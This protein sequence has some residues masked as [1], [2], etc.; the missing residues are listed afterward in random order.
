MAR[1]QGKRMA[2]MLRR[3]WQQ[4][5]EAGLLGA[6]GALPGRPQLRYISSATLCRA[7]GS[8]GASSG[9]FD[10]SS[11]ATRFDTF[12]SQRAISASSLERLDRFAPRHNALSKADEEEMCKAI[13]AKDM[14]DLMD[15]AIP[16]GLP[17][18]DGLDLGIYTKGMS[19]SEFL[20]H[21]KAMT[22]KNKVA[23]SYLGMGYYGTH[24]PQVIM[25]NLLENPGWYTQYTPYQSEIAQGRLESLLNFQTMVADLTAMEM[26]QSSL[27]DE[28]TAAAEAM[29]MTSAMAKGKKTRFVV[30]SNCHPQT[31]AVCQS[32]ADGLGLTVDVVDADKIEFASDVCGALVQYPAT[33]GSVATYSA[34]ADAAH[35]ADSKLCVATDLL[36]LTLLKPP[37]EWGADIVVGSAQRLGVPMGFG[38][39][40]AAF[41]ACSQKHQRLMPGRIIAI[42]KDANGK[43]A[44][45]MAMQ[46]RE[47]HIRRD[48][49]TSNICTA[50]A[51]LANMAAMY[52]V[53]HGP[54][55]L[56]AIAQRCH[57]MA[58]VVAEG[59]RRAGHTVAPGP[60]F[61]TVCMD[62]GD[63][64]A[65]VARGAEAGINI[66]QLDSG[67]ITVSVDETTTL[68]D[69]DA[70]LGVLRVG[71]G[72]SAAELAEAVDADM[73]GDLARTSS[74]MTNAVFNQYHSEH[75]MLRYLKHLENR[76]LSL[77]H[78]MIPLGSCTMKLN[79]TAEMVPISWPELA[80]IH[81]FAPTDQTA[82]YRAM[83]DALAQQL[84]EIT[85]FD[86]VSLQPNAGAAGEYAGLMSIRSYHQ[87]RGQGH[88]NI[89]IVPTSA[90]GT[91]P[92]SAVMCGM[93]VVVVKT[94]PSG[95][96]DMED[97]K[98]AVAKHSDN[99]AAFMITY[100]STYGLFDAEIQELCSIIHENGGQVYMDGANMNAQVGVTAPGILGADVC[101][102]N[103]HKT[104]CI[105]HG[106][107]GP[108]MG[109]IG[110]KAHLAPFLPSHPVIPTGGLPAPKDAT[111]APFGTMAAAPYGSALILPISFA[112]ISMMGSDGLRAATQQ[113]ILAANYM[114]EKLGG[115]Y[116]VLYQNSAGRCAHEFIIDLRGFET[117][118]GITP[119]DVAKRLLDY[120]FHG[121]TMSWPVPG[122]LM[123]EPTESEPK[124]E[125]DRFVEA[126]IQIR[127]E[128]AE[129]EDGTADKAN[130]LLKNA[131]HPLASVV[132]EEWKFPYSRER[133]TYPVPG[134]HERK[135]WPTMARVDNVYGDRKVV[136]R[137]P[138]D[139]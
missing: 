119:D 118:A 76:D 6:P 88:R 53:Y 19:E 50:Q 14:D 17:R 66:R 38:G 123:I 129:I 106:G 131:P 75:D 72:P 24:T 52:G 80:N 11:V 34:L 137:L 108:G 65:V 125:L 44:M 112:Y 4:E 32:R 79:G 86:S 114:K 99:L 56:K 120:G 7:Q 110:V 45:R 101:H 94:L 83:F 92:A 64:S 89:C 127:A 16:D 105:P 46:T 63:A 124:K 55:G 68:E 113:S 42:S 30:A 116:P 20:E 109:P 70:L 90:H 74:F 126:M 22:T 130:N 51:L 10:P 60:F 67:R 12:A 31:I 117:T 85:A 93:K 41:L 111:L 5:G 1:G 25:R 54:V 37:G 9:G 13:G 91:N 81:P 61:D 96:V 71:A 40:H 87:S 26:S 82:G 84:C 3:F 2:A 122:T 27:L 97:F 136:P 128:I 138:A 47:Q 43:P 21:F 49:A 121:P 57:A 133:A 48:K 100:P 39:P 73:P 77:C 33:D 134:L 8:N 102:L 29:T 98:A 58:A 95:E 15:S 135:F 78:S 132:A 35:A 28:A 23:K 139:E 59:A 104:F 103:L 107:G 69:L 62:V 115:H 18:L 36:S